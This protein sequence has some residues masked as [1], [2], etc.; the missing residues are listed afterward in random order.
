MDETEEA[1]RVTTGAVVYIA[2]ADIDVPK[3]INKTELPGSLD[4]EGGKGDPL[5]Y[6]HRDLSL[7]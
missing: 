7:L 1:R 2:G 5:Q 4:S 6:L 3:N